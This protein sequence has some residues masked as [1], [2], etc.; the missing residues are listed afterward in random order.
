MDSGCF[1]RPAV[2]RVKHLC[3]AGAVLAAMAVPAIGAGIKDEKT[4]GCAADAYSVYGAGQETC[5]TY[6]TEFNANPDPANIDAAYG[7]TL[8]WIAGYASAVNRQTSGR[9]IYDLDVRYMAT[10]IAK[11]CRANPDRMVSEG[12]DDLTDK[13]LKADRI[14]PAN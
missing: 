3:A 2:A 6:L 1:E 11:W 12:M 8:G 10:L 14:L 13:R 7:Q 5:S 4:C 9:D